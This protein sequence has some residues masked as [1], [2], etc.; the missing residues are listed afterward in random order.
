M[1]VIH[2][3]SSYLLKTC[4]ELLEAEKHA[5]CFLCKW[6]SSGVGEWVPQVRLSHEN[7]FKRMPDTTSPGLLRLF[8]CLTT[9]FPP[10]VSLVQLW[11]P[12]ECFSNQICFDKCGMDALWH[13]EM[14]L[15]EKMKFAHVP[16]QPGL[17][18]ELLDSED[19]SPCLSVFEAMCSSSEWVCFWPWC[20]LWDANLVEWGSDW[21]LLLNCPWSC[22]ILVCSSRKRRG[23]RLRQPS[24]NQREREID[25]YFSSGNWLTEVSPRL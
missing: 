8:F 13:K 9:L 18:S 15:K 14:S 11:T 21:T 3:S 20:R 19:N 1:A 25:F 24:T 16:L 23:I 4:Q 6:E 10:Q 7:D 2:P 12:W 22:F 5:C 17:S